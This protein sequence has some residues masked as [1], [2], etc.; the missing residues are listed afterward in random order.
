MNT[1][2]YDY[3]IKPRQVFEFEKLFNIEYC[4]Q[5]TIAPNYDEVFSP[6]AEIQIQLPVRYD[7]FDSSHL[8]EYVYFEEDNTIA[9]CLQ[10]IEKSFCSVKT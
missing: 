1:T 2:K 6:K 10:G 9:T 3:L 4:A 7:I 5:S 8:S